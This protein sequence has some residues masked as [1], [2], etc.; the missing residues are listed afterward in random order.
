MGVTQ[1]L[2]QYGETTVLL[3]GL[4]PDGLVRGDEARVQEAFG[5]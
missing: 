1:W 2:L 5:L 3:D 4:S